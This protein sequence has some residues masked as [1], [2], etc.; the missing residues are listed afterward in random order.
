MGM[1][2]VQ[3]EL[4]LGHPAPTLAS[5]TISSLKI[6][7]RGTVRYLTTG[8][9]A[10]WTDTSPPSCERTYHSRRF[11]KDNA[12]VTCSCKRSH[13]N[14][15]RQCLRNGV[16]HCG[17]YGVCVANYGAAWEIAGSPWLLKGKFSSGT[18]GALSS[19]FNYDFE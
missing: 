13:K 7:P 11:A 2:S 8:N 4:T 3:E 5:R 14:Q 10:E 12:A 16:E 9:T 18:E 15:T 6:H 17:S 1:C 19:T